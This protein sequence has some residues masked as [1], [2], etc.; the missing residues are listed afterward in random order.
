MQE[1][2]PWWQAHKKVIRK[3]LREWEANLSE[4]SATMDDLDAMRVEI[5]H[6]YNQLK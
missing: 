3:Y 2:N 1:N 4:W 6:L 5:N